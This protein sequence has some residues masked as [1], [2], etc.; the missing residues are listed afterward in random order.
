MLVPRALESGVRYFDYWELTLKEINWHLTAKQLAEKESF[1][2]RAQLD[3]QLASL[4]SRG[5][6]MA[7]GGKGKFPTLFAAYPG[8]FAEE[9]RAAKLDNIKHNMMSLS[10]KRKEENK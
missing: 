10:A 1:K 5:Q 9:E 6:A 2:Q 7:M 8:L 3:Y 4:I